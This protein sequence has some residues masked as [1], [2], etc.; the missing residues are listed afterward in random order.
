MR[1][2][3]G[4]PLTKGNFIFLK[5]GRNAGKTSVA[6]SSIR[7]FLAEDPSHKAIFVGLT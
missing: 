1:L 4:N 7:H 3:L 6:F 2:D 5:G